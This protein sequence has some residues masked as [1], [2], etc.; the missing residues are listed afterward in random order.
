MSARGIGTALTA[1]LL[2]LA[3][4][5]P[6]LVRQP[7]YTSEDG[8][9]DVQLR[10][11][12]GD[13]GTLG[14][15]YAHPA[16][17]SDVRLA[18][19]L[20]HLSYRGSDRD[21][22]PLIRSLQVF[23]LAEGLARAFAAAGPDDEVVAR[24]HMTDRRLQI[25]TQEKVTSFRAH[26][27]GDF[28]VLELFAVEEQVEKDPRNYTSHPY[29]PP[30]ELPTSGLRVELLAGEAHSLLG[31]RGFQIAWRDPV[32]RR[33]VSLSLRD[34]GIRRRTILMETDEEGP[35]PER[36]A[37]S[38]PIAPE[39]RDAQLSAL[40]RLDGVRRSGLITEAEFQRRRRLVLEGL[41]EEAGYGPQ[42]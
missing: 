31:S 1:A 19:I 25:F 42:P 21:T 4:C 18:H 2:A 13:G 40:D 24:A 15:G 6:E 33:P 17:I 36:P 3:G 26:F 39:L 23:D 12:L 14:R 22:L 30:A 34:G 11:T 38:V 20:A 27:E 37:A 29:E 28:L 16:V 7:I 10:R 5:G 41:L 8:R 32:F 9:V 35:V